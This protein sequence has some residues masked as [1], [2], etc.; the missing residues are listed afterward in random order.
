[1]SKV[2]ISSGL[3]G[4]AVITGASSGIGAIYADQLARAGIRSD[5]RRSQ[6]RAPQR[7]SKAC[8]LMNVTGQP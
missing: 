6:S 7:D 3:K 4:T 5:P 1:L 8:Q 2:L